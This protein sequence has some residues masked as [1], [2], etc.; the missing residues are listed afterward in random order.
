[1]K[2]NIVYH[3]VLEITDRIITEEGY[4]VCRSYLGIYKRKTTK[5]IAEI[6][7]FYKKSVKEKYRMNTETFD[8]ITN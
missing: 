2:N 8:I 6:N 5:R 4:F 7:Y 1:M 3:V